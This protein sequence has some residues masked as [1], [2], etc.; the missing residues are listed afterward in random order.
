MGGWICE[1]IGLLTKSYLKGCPLAEK[2]VQVF[3]EPPASYSR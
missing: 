3:S 1:G 2:Y